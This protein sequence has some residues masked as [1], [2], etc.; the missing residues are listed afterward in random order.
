MA[1][2][3]EKK[4]LINVESNLDEYTKEV[5][6]TTKEVEKWKEAQ[7][8]AEEQH[9]KNS[10]E[11]IE[12]TAQLK[13]A[14]KEQRQATATLEK[15]TAAQKA[16]GTSY[17]ALYKQWDAAQLKLKSLENTLVQNADGTF[18]LTEEYK[19]AA[20]EV[21]NA[22]NALNNFTTGVKDGRNNV[23]LS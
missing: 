18:E 16:N 20:I 17:N 1:A 7:K 4:Y 21:A 15:M 2:T 9:T 3:E 14:Q 12:A 23:G 10:K 5:Q 22:K 8:E 6:R 19:K 11:Y 13:V